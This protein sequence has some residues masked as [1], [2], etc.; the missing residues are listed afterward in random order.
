M[1]HQAFSTSDFF[2]TVSRILF[3]IM[4]KAFSEGADYSDFLMENGLLGLLPKPIMPL[5]FICP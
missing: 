1:K 3:N 5:E 2:D 4:V